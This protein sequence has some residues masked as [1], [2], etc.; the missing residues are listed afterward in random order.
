MLSNSVI[1][2]IIL[3]LIMPEMNG[4]DFLTEMERLQIKIP[5]IVM[6]GT[7]NEG[8]RVCKLFPVV[9]EVLEKPFSQKKLLQ[10]CSELSG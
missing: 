9:L 8:F 1:D 4:E 7:V 5:V 6:T 10:L 3:D 2:L